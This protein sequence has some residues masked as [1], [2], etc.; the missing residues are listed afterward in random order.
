MRV[1]GPTDWVSPSDL[2]DHSYVEKPPAADGSKVI[3][4]DTDH[5][6]IQLKV[7]Y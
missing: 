6:E 3:Q 1:T 4:N 2:I 7:A 5:V